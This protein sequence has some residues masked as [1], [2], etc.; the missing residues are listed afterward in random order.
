M[1]RD[2]VAAIFWILL[3]VVISIWSSTFPFGDWKAPGPA[4]LPLATGL[5]LILLG[6]ILLIQNRVTKKGRPRDSS[7][8]LL[9]RGKALAKVAATLGIIVLSTLSLEALG[10]IVTTFL[11]LLLLKETIQA[12]KVKTALFYAFVSTLGCV[13]VFQILLKVRFP[14][15]PFGF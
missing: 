4:F 14:K 7:K 1:R 12:E 9:P 3:G 5:I 13:I 2:L 11:M 15:G 8:T 6:G 10:F